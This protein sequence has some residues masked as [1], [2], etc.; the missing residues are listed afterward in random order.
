MINETEFTHEGAQYLAEW[1]EHGGKVV[2]TGI[3]NPAGIRLKPMRSTMAG[4][5]A[6]AVGVIEGE[7][8]TK[9]I[10]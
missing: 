5:V 2:V 6:S 4:I 3:V 9:E 8:T 1:Y 7:L 10:L